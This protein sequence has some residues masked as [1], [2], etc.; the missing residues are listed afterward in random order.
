MES[1][2]DINLKKMAKEIYDLRYPFCVQIMDMIMPET[3]LIQYD[4]VEIYKNWNSFLGNK[5]ETFSIFLDIY[6]NDLSMILAL[7]E[8]ILTLNSFDCKKEE[9]T[10]PINDWQKMN[11]LIKSQ[12]AIYHLINLTILLRIGYERLLLC[13][14]KLFNSTDGKSFEKKKKN[15]IKKLIDY[16]DFQKLVE[17]INVTNIKKYR[18]NIIH[19]NGI[20][21]QEFICNSNKKNKFDV[22]KYLIEV[23]KE[24][25]IFYKLL[26]QFIN[27]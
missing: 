4:L 21:F 10:E 15:L 27:K 1:D 17:S 13:L 25:E 22:N 14:M 18:D 20:Y 12:P 5:N 3:K 16:Q 23:R 9:Y 26:I 7:K 6:L 11:L 2:L 19:H 24:I 8:S